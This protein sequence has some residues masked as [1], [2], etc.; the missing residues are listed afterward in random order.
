MPQVLPYSGAM[1]AIVAR[2]A[3]G[4]LASPSPKNS[5]NLS[6]TPFFRSISVTVRTRSVAVAREL[7]GG[8]GRERL[9]RAVFVDL[10]GVVDDQLGGIQRV[11]ALGVAAE[12]HDR[13]AHRGEI[14]HARHASEVLEDDARR[15]EDDLVRRGRPRIT[16]EQRLDFGDV[17]ATAVL[18]AHT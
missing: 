17:H 9:G 5:T 18:V 2:S 1:L 4:R 14:H 13:I 10:H 8:I 15:S 7:H 6:T 3:S 11:D 16:L 12:A